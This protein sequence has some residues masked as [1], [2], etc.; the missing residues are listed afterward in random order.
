MRRSKFLIAHI[1][2][3]LFFI[4]ALIIALV[5][6]YAFIKFGMVEAMADNICTSLMLL[7]TACVFIPFCVAVFVMRLKFLN[8]S[9]KWVVLF[10]IPIANLA[11]WIYL[12][13]RA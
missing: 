12:L 11:L 9:P 5:L 1:K 7:F 8:H 2:L 13:C 6:N 4:V 3:A 10:F